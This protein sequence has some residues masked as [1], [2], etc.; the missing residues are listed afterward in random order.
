MSA[1][2]NL[3]IRFSGHRDLFGEDVRELVP[4]DQRDPGIYTELNRLFWRESA[5]SKGCA[6]KAS[7]ESKD[8]D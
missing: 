5:D 4:V 7:G 2:T 6:Y 1:A 8:L 3:T